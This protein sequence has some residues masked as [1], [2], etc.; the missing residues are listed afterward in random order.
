M[1]LAGLLMLPLTAIITATWIIIAAALGREPSFRGPFFLAYAL[2]TLLMQP[3]HIGSW[4]EAG[5][6]LVMLVMSAVPI[7]GGCVA[8]GIPARLI[9]YL[10]R[11]LAQTRHS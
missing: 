9:V 7:A 2:A 3:W 11:K 4:Q 1:V 8:G 6:G 10:M 5:M